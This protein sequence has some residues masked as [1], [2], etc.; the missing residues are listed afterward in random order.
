VPGC[1]NLNLLKDLTES[2]HCATRSNP[3]RRLW[4][5]TRWDIK[6]TTPRLVEGRGIQVEATGVKPVGGAW[7]GHPAGKP[8]APMKRAGPSQLPGVRA[9]VT[10]LA[11]AADCTGCWDPKCNRETKEGL[12]DATRSAL[13]HSF[14]SDR[15][16][17]RRPWMVCPQYCCGQKPVAQ[18]F[19]QVSLLPNAGQSQMTRPSSLMWQAAR[20]SP[21]KPRTSPRGL[22]ALRIRRDRRR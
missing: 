10:V 2:L 19:N 4:T 18:R 11:A 5:P 13:P 14:L 22:Q 6:R 3:P 12:T 17:I 21:P 15:G 16:K 8:A 9:N 7:L 1:G 20:P